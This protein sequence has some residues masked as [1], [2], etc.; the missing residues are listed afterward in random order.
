MSEAEKH[1]PVLLIGTEGEWAGRSF[2]SVLASNG[3]KVLRAEDGRD[4]LMWA[5]RVKPDAILLDEHLAGVH[6]GGIEV[7]RQ[8]R[9]DPEFDAATPIVLIASAPSNRSV[10]SE[11]LRAG[12][13]LVCTQPLDTETLFL[14]LGTFIRA[15]RAV[16]DARAQAF[17]DNATGLLTP[18]GMQRWAEKLAARA[19]RNHE[20]LAC[21]VLMPVAA[22]AAEAPANSRETM[23]EFLD[24]ARDVFRRSDVVGFLA[25][26]RLALLAPDTDTEG[27]HGFLARL[28]AAITEAQ[29][30]KSEKSGEA[31]AAFNAGYWAIDDFATVKMDP[32]ELLR[33]ATEA[34]D[35]MNRSR[36]WSFQPGF[37]RIPTS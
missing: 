27:V 17:V 26:G 36:P 14:E 34:F 24:L 19:K 20:S 28:R 23:Q 30:G 35:Q 13:W 9:E 12:A 11:A 29:K 22:G 16:T 37:G 33:R 25:D 7:C 10:R 31:A 32:S 18:L 8:L 4:A 6:G 21:V 5:T 2:E 15:K 1:P 3:Y